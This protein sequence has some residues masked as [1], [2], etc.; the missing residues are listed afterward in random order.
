MLLVEAELSDSFDSMIFN[1][2]RY[3]IFFDRKVGKLDESYLIVSAHF[4]LVFF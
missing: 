4:N 3:E 2:L 1:I